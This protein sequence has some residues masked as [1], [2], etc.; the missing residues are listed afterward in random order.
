[1]LDRNGHAAR[2]NQAERAIRRQVI[3]IG[4]TEIPWLHQLRAVT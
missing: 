4:H 1:M 3:Q 2:E